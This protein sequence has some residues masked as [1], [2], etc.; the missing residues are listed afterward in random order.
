MLDKSGQLDRIRSLDGKLKSIEQKNVSLE[1]EN[2]E[3]TKKVRE[4]LGIDENVPSPSSENDNYM[5]EV[6]DR[7]L[8][9]QKMSLIKSPKNEVRIQFRFFLRG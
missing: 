9:R 6:A 3:M 2:I 8:E 1:K 5:D 7:H 4:N